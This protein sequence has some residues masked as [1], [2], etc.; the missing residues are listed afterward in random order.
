MTDTGAQCLGSPLSMWDSP[1]DMDGDMDISMLANFNEQNWKC[2]R[3]VPVID[4]TNEAVESGH[5]T[6]TCGVS[7]AEVSAP[8]VECGSGLHKALVITASMTGP[9]QKPPMA[10]LHT[11]CTCF[12]VKGGVPAIEASLKSIRPSIRVNIKTNICDDIVTGLIGHER[13]HEMQSCAHQ[14]QL[15]ELEIYAMAN[16]V[17]VGMVYNVLVGG[18]CVSVLN[19]GVDLESKHFRPQELD[20][21]KCCAHPNLVFIEPA[22]HN[23]QGYN[24]GTSGAADYWTS[25]NTSQKFPVDSHNPVISKRRGCVKSAKSSGCTQKAYF[26]EYMLVKSD[27]RVQF[28]VFVLAASDPLSTMQAYVDS[29]DTGRN[30]VSCV[31]GQEVEPSLRKLVYYMA[32]VFSSKLI[33]KQWDPE[34]VHSVESHVVPAK[35]GAPADAA[36]ALSQHDDYTRVQVGHVP[37]P[38][39]PRFP[40]PCVQLAEQVPGFEPLMYEAV[41]IAENGDMKRAVRNLLEMVRQPIEPLSLDA[42][43][44]LNCYGYWRCHHVVV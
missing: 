13:G 37:M 20:T 11:I 6:P 22:H 23:R 15:S 25:K 2:M 42:F 27:D 26:D 7:N 43:E 14:W 40:I 31:A 18:S 5:N 4:F 16:A 28:K 33:Q 39:T 38:R 3:G 29:M 19:N 44:C 21:S 8:T 24:R 34:Y 1:S 41:L 35:R 12:S 17:T 10:V 32:L 36:V 9:Q 30:G